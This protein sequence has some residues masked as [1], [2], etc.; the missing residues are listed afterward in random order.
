MNYWTFYF[1]NSAPIPIIWL[2][3]RLQSILILPLNTSES[4]VG[5]TSLK[6]ISY[7]NK[8]TK[9]NTSQT[10][11]A[12]GML[13]KDERTEGCLSVHRLVTVI[14]TPAESSNQQPGLPAEKCNHKHNLL[15][16]HE[17]WKSTAKLSWCLL[18]SPILQATFR[19]LCSKITKNWSQIER[20]SSFSAP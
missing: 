4:P 9:L 5:L 13:V 1:S 16:R 8:T 3:P 15:D 18:L 6:N 14:I 7:L 19:L 2:T 11:L 12:K 17:H 20:C 10:R